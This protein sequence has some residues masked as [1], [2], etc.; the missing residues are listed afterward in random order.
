M[1]RSEC[2]EWLLFARDD[3]ESASFLLG[4]SPR[5]LE[6][7]CFHCQQAAEKSLKAIPALFDEEVPKSHDLR[8]LLRLGSLHFS[9]LEVLA[10]ILPRLQPYAVAVRYPHESEVEP[11]DEERAIADALSVLDA[12]EKALQE[13]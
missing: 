7:I 2:E 6:I 5:K 9:E 11:G 4:M 1:G 3:L 8:S 13:D 10:A 12:I